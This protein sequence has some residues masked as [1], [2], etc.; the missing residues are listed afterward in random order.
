MTGESCLGS[1]GRDTLLPM[2]KLVGPVLFSSEAARR[3]TFVSALTKVPSTRSHQVTVPGTRLRLVRLPRPKKV[4]PRFPLDD[5][6]K[7]SHRRLGPDGVEAAVVVWQALACSTAG[8]C[9]A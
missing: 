4:V 3:H 2:Q 8:R 1:F 6:A 7:M 5:V 9:P